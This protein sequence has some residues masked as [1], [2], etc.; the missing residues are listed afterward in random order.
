M[1]R[2]N[3]FVSNMDHVK[4]RRDGGADHR[5]S[6]AVYRDGGAIHRDSKAKR[7]YKVM[8]LKMKK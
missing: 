3:G 4:C 5:D 1:F 2:P 7:F 8:N 6:E